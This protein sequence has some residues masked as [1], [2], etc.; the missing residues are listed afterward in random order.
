MTPKAPKYLKINILLFLAAALV[1]G[2]LLQ[3]HY[4]LL[5]GE[6]TRS[7]CSISAEVDCDVVNTSAYSEVA[8]IPVSAIALGYYI[9][10]MLLS[11]IGARNVLKRREVLLTLFPLTCVSVIVSVVMF[12]IM[13]FVLKT[14]CLLCLT[15]KA[16]DI[17]T[18]ALTFAALRDFKGGNAFSD[19]LKKASKKRI[20]AYLAVGAI[21][22]LIGHALSSQLKNELPFESDQFVG[23]FKS[24]PALD[25]PSGDSPKLGYTAENPPVQIVEFADFQCPAC[26]MASNYMNRLVQKYGDR[27]QLVFKHFPLDSSCNPHVKARVHDHACA[28]AKAAICAHRQGKFKEYYQLLFANQTEINQTALR[29]WAN[30]VQLKADEFEACLSSAETSMALQKDMDLGHA[31]GLRSTPTFFVN[32]RRVEGAIDEARLQAILKELGK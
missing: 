12:A 16:L 29:K 22:I 3:H 11:F 1:S 13:A 27:V 26:A 28:A 24:Q 2:Y 25:V 21:F 20:T 30:K 19:E 23:D 5:N 7:F 9:L 17:A 18:F 10:A 8:G 6:T 14:Y 32:G 31:V 15:L 4:A